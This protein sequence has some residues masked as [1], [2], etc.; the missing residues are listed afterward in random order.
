MKTFTQ[1]PDSTFFLFLAPPAWGKTR[2][3]EQIFDESEVSMIFVSP[4]R[5]L[6]LEVYER[7]KKKKNVL[8]LEKASDE[9]KNLRLF[10]QNQK[11]FLIATPET[12]GPQWYL[13]FES[14][15]QKPLVVLD[16]FH[17]YYLWGETFRPLLWESV[18]AFSNAGVN[19]LALTATMDEQLLKKWKHD[20][21][22]NFEH[23]IMINQ[24]NLTLLRPPQRTHFYFSLLP[25]IFRRR[26]IRDLLQ[27]QEQT[28]LYFCS[29]RHEVDE[30]LDFC[31]RRGIS[32]LGCKGGEVAHFIAELK[33]NPKPRAIFSTSAL[34]HGVN[35]PELA[36]VYISY[37]I[38]RKDMWLQMV[39]R[40][41]RKGEVYELFTFDAFDLKWKEKV[42]KILWS[43]LLDLKIKGTL[44]LG[45]E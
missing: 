7:F 4:L 37:P 15:E 3:I 38:E 39:G 44:L 19:I 11:S 20:F 31:E 1:F 27:N 25:K 2:M 33:N 35:L 43:L 16:E 28:Y 29:R 5:A 40:G 23:L 8:Y 9:Q 24:G 14:L 45:S 41:G 22:L 13:A 32:A 26:F 30:W 21:A 10:M 36:K 18:M 42:K 6:A 34:S 17:L 12:L